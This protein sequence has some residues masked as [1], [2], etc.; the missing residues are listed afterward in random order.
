MD[1]PVEIPKIYSLLDKK[2]VELRQTQLKHFYNLNVPLSEIINTEDYINDFIK[3][4]GLEGR[5]LLADIKH[6]RPIEEIRIND[7]STSNRLLFDVLYCTSHS[8][9]K[10]KAEIKKLI[11]QDF[12]CSRYLCCK[13]SPFSNNLSVL[14]SFATN[15]S[16][17]CSAKPLIK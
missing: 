15:I 11:A 9:H 1:I 4:K 3:I 8:L 10:F 5:P 12:D 13:A 6:F 7:N 2:A 14:S 16:L 17:K